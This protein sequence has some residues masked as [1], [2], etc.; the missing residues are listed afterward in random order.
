MLKAT[1]TKL[2][3][4]LRSHSH[5]VQVQDAAESS[6]RP[7]G[8]DSPA[9]AP[10]QPLINHLPLEVLSRIFIFALP[11]D[12]EFIKGKR[13]F[14]P[15]LPN[16][17]SFCA[18]CSLWRSFALGTPQLWKRVFVYVPLSISGAEARL[19]AA[20]L[21]SWIERSAPLSL[22][23]FISYGIGTS[24]VELGPEA[25]IVHVLNR[26]A[27]RWGALYL[28]YAGNH[29][30]TASELN[31]RLF[32]F[33]GW[34]S[35]QRIYS[36]RNYSGLKGDKAA[37]WGQLTH[38]EICR[39]LPYREVL[40]IFKG[41]AK[42]EWLSICV[43]SSASFETPPCPIILHHVSF[44]SLTADGASISPIMQSICLPSLQDMSLRL[45]LWW[46]TPINFVPILQFLTRSACTLHKLKIN[47]SRAQPKDLV[48]LLA[49]P[50]CN[51]LTSLTID[52]GDLSAYG[53]VDEEV[54]RRL[55]LHQDDALCTRLKSL[56]LAHCI[57][58]VQPWSFST[59]LTMVESRI[60]S[61]A[62]QPQDELLGYLNLEIKGVDKVKEKLDEIIKRSGM[63]YDGREI[64]LRFYQGCGL[65][66][67]R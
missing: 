21:I 25:P 26:Y 24:L 61:C 45:F 41:C 4:G 63:Q 56:T 37:P 3:R 62:G 10:K 66:C 14:M 13:P 50:S 51:F 6:A 19:K 67:C 11:N 52:D 29:L 42:L 7:W 28:Q 47:A 55:T 33:D 30:K 12:E 38:L 18:V 48:R 15:P 2:S 16:P 57:Q 36:L 59:L 1:L 39:N 20:Y 22:T 34:S 54:L 49:H 32:S 53:A 44:I 5:T 23:L 17:L 64:V 43:E 65:P 27:T 9:R 40:Y 58:V 31:S 8:D 60:G 35:L 46:Q